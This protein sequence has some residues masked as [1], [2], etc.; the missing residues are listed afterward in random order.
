MK[1]NIYLVITVAAFAG[2]V[3]GI[4]LYKHKKAANQQVLENNYSM[5]EHQTMYDYEAPVFG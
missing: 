5:D 2:T 1:K 3:F 4:I